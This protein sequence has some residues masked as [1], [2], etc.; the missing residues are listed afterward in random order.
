[1][2]MIVVDDFT[3]LDNA[4]IRPGL[5]RCPSARLSRANGHEVAAFVASEGVAL[6]SSNAD[7]PIQCN[8][9]ALLRRRT[10]RHTVPGLLAA[11]ARLACLVPIEQS[12]Q[13][14]QY[15][16]NPFHGTKFTHSF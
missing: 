16:R 11:D 15:N 5:R 4:G 14:R 12:Q 2:P 13:Q 1:M 8:I 10:R 3:A 7:F 6:R 9:I